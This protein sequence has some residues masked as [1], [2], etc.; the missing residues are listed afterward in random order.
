[1]L[2]E[3][4]LL[5][6]EASYIITLSYSGLRSGLCHD[7]SNKFILFLAKNCLALLEQKRKNSCCSKRIFN[8]VSCDIFFNLT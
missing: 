6:L 2:A 3:S 5:A 8:R 7:Q 4:F 1:M